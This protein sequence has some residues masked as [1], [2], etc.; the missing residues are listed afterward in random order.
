MLNVRNVNKLIGSRQSPATST[1]LIWTPRILGNRKHVSNY[2]ATG[3]DFDLKKTKPDPRTKANMS[4]RMMT[5]W[6]ENL[7]KGT[8]GGKSNEEGEKRRQ[9]QIR[10]QLER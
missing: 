7:V 10:V 6:K 2:W 3:K 5:D 8:E 9:K 1:R 4:L